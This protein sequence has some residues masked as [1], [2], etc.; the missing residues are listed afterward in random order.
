VA[1]QVPASCLWVRKN[2][3][4]NQRRTGVRDLLLLRRASSGALSDNIRAVS[5][6]CGLGLFDEA[7]VDD[8]PAQPA[9]INSLSM[10]EGLSKGLSETLKVCD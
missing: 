6:T 3:V 7:V 4:C 10:K 5:P 8:S 9:M 1:R 2:H